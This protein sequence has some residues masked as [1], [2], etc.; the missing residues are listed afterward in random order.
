MSCAILVLDSYLHCHSLSNTHLWVF[1]IFLN[2]PLAPSFPNL[3]Y[4]LVTRYA[5][6]DI[7]PDIEIK[8]LTQNSKN[9]MNHF[10]QF[11]ESIQL[12]K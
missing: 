3:F 8:H 12:V 1:G 2:I 7:T 6:W 10:E 4:Q 11:Q 9:I 5:P